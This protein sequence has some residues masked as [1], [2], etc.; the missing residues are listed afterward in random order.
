MPAAIVERQRAAAA[1]AEASTMAAAADVARS[2]PARAAEPA[3]TAETTPQSSNTFGWLLR[4]PSI[5]WG[6]LVENVGYFL[7]GRHT[8]LL[9]YF[10]FVLLSVGLYL[11]FSRT[12][13]RTLLLVAL[14]GIA[15]FFLV[16]IA[17][18]WHGGGGFV[19]N[20]YYVVAVPGFLFL[21]TTIRPPW[22][23]L[24]GYAAAGLLL[25]PMLLT[26]FGA[27]VPEPTLQSH[28]RDFPLRELP[29]ELSLRNVPGYHTAQLGELRLVGRQ[30][31]WL[32]QG[33]SLA[34]AGADA[35]ELLVLSLEPLLQE[36]VVSVESPAAGRVRVAWGGDEKILDL[37]AGETRQVALQPERAGRRYSPTNVSW[38][39]SKLAIESDRGAL[40]PWTRRFPP[41]ECPQFAYNESIEETFYTGAVVRVLGPRAFLERDRWAARWNAVVAPEAVVAGERFAVSAQIANASGAPWDGFGSAQVH[42]SYRWLDAGGAVVA[43]GLR[44]PLPR[45]V[46]PGES[47][48]VEIAVEAPPRSGS[49]TLALE[50]VLEFVSW[51][52]DRDPGAVRRI[53]VVV[54]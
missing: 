18:N 36:I 24:A 13:E 23:P 44:T 49:Y 50:P 10:P 46:A 34:V 48:E 40:R 32:P 8:G 41:P 31:Q 11:A 53:A 38:W 37:G 19:G 28:T 29:L 47:V 2:G 39:V 54:E 26:P 21:V 42:L 12:L 33:P 1:A 27:G 15:L 16:F 43:E 45:V 25:G 35:V 30:D 6:K 52:G 9:P 4:V 22:L 5:H 7:W 14:A 20:R 17:W 51:F 3:P